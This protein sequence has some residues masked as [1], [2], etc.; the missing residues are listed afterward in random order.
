MSWPAIRRWPKRRQV[1][2]SDVKANLARY[3]VPREVVV[4]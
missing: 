2:E 3:K 1:T 4:R